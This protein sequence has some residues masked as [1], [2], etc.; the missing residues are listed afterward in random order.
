[1]NKRELVDLVSARLG[2]TKG[3]TE[4]VVDVVLREIQ[5]GLARDGEVTLVGFGTFE[6]RERAARNGR[7]PRTGAPMEIPA[8]TS[9]LFRPARA[10]RAALGGEREIEAGA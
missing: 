5:A 8:G 7:N 3:A 4:E 10:L 2:S 9:V 6:L 1:M